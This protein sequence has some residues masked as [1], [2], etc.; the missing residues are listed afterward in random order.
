MGKARSGKAAEKQRGNKSNKSADERAVDISDSDSDNDRP[1]ERS[2][3][4]VEI[5]PETR[6]GHSPL[7]LTVV[8][9]DDAARVSKSSN[10][11]EVSAKMGKRNRTFFQ[12]LVGHL[13][14]AK[15]AL[16][17]DKS[18]EQQRKL[19]AAAQVRINE[20]L[21]KDRSDIELKRRQEEAR[22][23]RIINE[24]MNLKKRLDTHYYAQTATPLYVCLYFSLSTSHSDFFSIFL[25]HVCL[26]SST[27]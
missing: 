19:Q 15:L 20:Q 21:K 7:T 4:P 26:C 11:N 22:R 9:D 6:L 14:K 3:P 18:T 13:G 23:R 16:E 17:N 12:K 8:E 2:P 24:Q 1:K 25:F 27:T 10:S 5:A